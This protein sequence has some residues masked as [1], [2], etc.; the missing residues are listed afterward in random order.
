M[1]EAR[2]TLVK[3]KVKVGGSEQRCKKTIAALKTARQQLA[4]EAHATVSTLLSRHIQEKE[5]KVD[6][7]FK[8]L[9]KDDAI[10]SVE[11]L[12]GFAKNIP[13]INSAL[14]D[15]ALGRY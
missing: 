10:I 6:E 5:L 14:L 13:E 1:G 8:E 12:R 11:S 4:T 15:I 3:L 2:S 9:C 7:L